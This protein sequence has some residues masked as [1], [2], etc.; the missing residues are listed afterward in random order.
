MID[1]ELRGVSFKIPNQ[2]GKYLKDILNLVEQKELEKCLIVQSEVYD[3]KMRNLLHCGIYHFTDLL[4]KV[5]ESYINYLNLQIWGEIPLK[6]LKEVSNYQDF[7]TS[8]CIIVI[9]IYDCEFVEIYSKNPDV[10]LTK[11]QKR[12][13]DN[14]AGI[15]KDNDS[16]YIFKV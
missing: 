1:K 16:R 3:K 12:Y 6:Q 9:L 11:C 14:C 5:E 10:L 2:Y 13:G 4:E 8:A 15:Y 7:I